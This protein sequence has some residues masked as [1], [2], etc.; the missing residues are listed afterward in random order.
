MCLEAPGANIYRAAKL[1]PSGHRPTR[2]STTPASVQLT[3]LFLLVDLLGRM[4][5][6]KFWRSGEALFP[7]PAFEKTVLPVET[8]AVNETALLLVAGDMVSEVGIFELAGTKTTL[9]CQT[10]LPES[11]PALST[12]EAVSL[13]PSFS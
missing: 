4:T 10:P 9:G 13:L 7:A 3:L 11:L 1:R 5:D 6:S 12:L 8:K 2:L